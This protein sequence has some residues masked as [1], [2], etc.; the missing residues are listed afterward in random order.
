VRI[1]AFHGHEVPLHG[2]RALVGIVSAVLHVGTRI[3]AQFLSIPSGSRQ[4]KIFSSAKALIG[5]IESVLDF[6]QDLAE[7]ADD[8]TRPQLGD[9]VHTSDMS[10]V[11]GSEAPGDA[12]RIGSD[13]NSC[14]ASRTRS[15]QPGLK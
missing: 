11:K 15:R 13:K 8:P 12:L 3:T 4:L 6:M 2:E 7:D 9:R 5:S 1:Y 14:P 10:F